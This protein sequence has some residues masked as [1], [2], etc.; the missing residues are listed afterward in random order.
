MYLRCRLRRW[1]FE[2]WFLLLILGNFW[3]VRN[4]PLFRSYSL[5]YFERL[6][7]LRYCIM[8]RWSLTNCFGRVIHLSCQRFVHCYIRLGCYCF[9]NCIC[10][11]RRKVSCLLD[12]F[13]LLQRTISI[14]WNYIS[15]VYWKLTYFSNF[16]CL[17]LF[18]C[19]SF[20]PPRQ[21]QQI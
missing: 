19:S 5:I 13:N 3:R 14:N 17:L 6:W 12:I 21:V 4:I 10:I 7:R 16:S 1:W 20:Y 2:V 8:L 11:E 15:C 18:F 9:E